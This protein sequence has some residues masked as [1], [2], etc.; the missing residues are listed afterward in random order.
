LKARNC[1]VTP[2]IAWAT[3][4]ARRRLV[5]HTFENVKSYIEGK[6]LNVVNA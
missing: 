4:A 5:E 1:E 3:I 2:H 6:P